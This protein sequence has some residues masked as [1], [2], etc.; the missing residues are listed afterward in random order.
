MNRLQK[1][2]RYL[3]TGITILPMPLLS[4]PLDSVFAR[5]D[6]CL[7]IEW[8]PDSVNTSSAWYVENGSKCTGSDTVYRHSDFIAGVTYRSI[9]YSYGGED[10]YYVFREKV[11]SGFLVGS[12]L[13]HYNTF[14][15][16]SSVIAGTDCSGFVCYVWDVPRMSTGG[17]AED[18]RFQHISKAAIEEGD[19]LVKAG[20][21]T[22]L[23]V[24]K[25]D[26][27]HF[28]IWEST[29]AVNGCRER[30]INIGDSAWNPYIPL[31]NPGISAHSSE[32]T[33]KIDLISS[34]SVSWEKTRVSLHL[35]KPS[36]GQYSLYHAAGRRIA[37]FTVSISSS[38]II[39]H[40]PTPISRGM[41]LLKFVDRHGSCKI[42]RLPV[43]R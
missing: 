34:F 38:S 39:W 19:I 29:S 33:K 15:D 40:L 43:F 24:E 16:P 11:A 12:H 36:S 20:S 28:L 10:R 8:T 32:I 21:H 5:G 18:S 42:M 35:N 17:L 9:A 6:S 26:S 27:T 13:C 37:D 7:A 4:I 31:R 30:L 2:I 14:G 23:V 41:Y 3:L 22:V 25:D 1:Q